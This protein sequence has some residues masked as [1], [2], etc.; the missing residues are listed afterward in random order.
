MKFVSFTGGAGRGICELPLSCSSY[1]EN[2]Q[3]YLLVLYI[4]GD[5][6]RPRDY[7]TFSMLISAEYEI[8]NAHRYEHI[9]K[10][11]LINKKLHNLR[12][13]CLVERPTS[14][15]DQTSL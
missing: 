3:D 2:E 13:K 14:S 15:L 8:L 1:S 10:F 11:M 6:P 7:E 4:A 9:K 12:T 5:V